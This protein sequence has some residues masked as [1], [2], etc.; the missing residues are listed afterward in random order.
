MDKCISFTDLKL[1]SQLSHMS[2]IEMLSIENDNIMLYYLD[3]LGVDVQYPTM[4]LP[5][6]HR[7]MQGKVVVGFR[8]CGEIQHNR[9]FT[10]SDYCLPMERVAITGQYDRSLTQELASLS[11]TT[12]NHDAF[13]EDQIDD[14]ANDPYLD[15][16]VEASWKATEREIK[17]L[18]ELR[19]FI[20]GPLYNEAGSPKS[21]DEYQ[22]YLKGVITEE[23]V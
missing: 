8:A 19:D 18:E 11:G 12:L 23:N 20:R 9:A 2:E 22:D 10:K 16:Y 21:R 15:E 7:N 17:V 13:H 3:K 5:S 14:S 4:Y 1:I 6:R